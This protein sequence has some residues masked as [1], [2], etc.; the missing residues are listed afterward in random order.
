MYAQNNIQDLILWA[1]SLVVDYMHKTWAQTLLSS[2]HLSLADIDTT[3]QK[4]EKATN[5]EDAAGA[6]TAAVPAASRPREGDGDAGNGNKKAKVAGGSK[7]CC[8]CL[9]AALVCDLHPSFLSL[10]LCP[11]PH[12]NSP[13]DS[14]C[15]HHLSFAGE[16]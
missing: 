12:A 14:I 8:V 2:L 11:T 6:A 7:V 13:R 5:S 4:R 16:R 9:C 3:S 10:L 15:P 1:A